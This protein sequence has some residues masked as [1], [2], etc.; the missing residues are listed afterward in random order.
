VTRSLTTTIRQFLNKT[1]EAY[2]TLELPKEA[3]ARGRRTAALATKGDNRAAKGKATSA[4]ARKRLNLAT[5]K[6]HA[7]ADYPETIRR[8]GT[9]D[10]Y[11]TQIVRSYPQA[12][13]TFSKLKQHTQGELEHRRVK[14]FYARTNKNNPTRQITKH[15]RR[16]AIIQSLASRDPSSGNGKRVYKVRRP[17]HEGIP[18]MSPKDHH[19]IAESQRTY[20]DILV[21]VH[22]NRTNPGVKVGLRRNL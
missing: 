20:Y 11:S 5:Y 7:L 6:Y 22:E 19:H 3:A 13:S 14:R 17:E 8:F 2:I 9:T 15:Q 16:E 4:P 21:W 12:C 10:N 1:C 18:F